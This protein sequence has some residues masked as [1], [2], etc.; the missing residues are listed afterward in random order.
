M[1]RK[2][3]TIEDVRRDNFVEYARSRTVGMLRQRYDT[4]V[5]EENAE[6]AA[7]AARDYRNALLEAWDNMMVPDRPG[8]NV[9]AWMA[10]RQALRDVPEQQGF[11]I[12]IVWP[13]KPE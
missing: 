8:V 1:E 5:A 3:Q 6:D 9:E 7:D 10:Y 2:I 12:S 4:A 13:E 11:P